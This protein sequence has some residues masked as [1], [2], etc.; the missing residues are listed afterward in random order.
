ML[1]QQERFLNL[2]TRLSCQLSAKTQLWSQIVAA[3]S[4][5]H[6]SYHTIDHIGECLQC[7]DRY[8]HLAQH[9]IE[10][11]FALWL[12]DV[13]YH[14][15]ATDNELQSALWAMNILHQGGVC[16]TIQQ[17][18]YALILASQHGMTTPQTS[19]EKLLVDIDLSIFSATAE[20]FALYQQQIRREYAQIPEI[21]FQQKR[22]AF[23]TTFVQSQSIYYTPVIRNELEKQARLN[24][25]HAIT[26][27]RHNLC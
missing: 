19:D 12:H 3:Y 15:L 8:Q 22:K 20:R 24:L 1:I 27:L 21:V 2:L 11:E 7:F 17:R 23:L 9:P 4:Q 6:R 16:K 25:Q 5:H 14:P 10:V 26:N 18:I 13:V